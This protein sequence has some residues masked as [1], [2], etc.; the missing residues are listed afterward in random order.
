MRYIIDRFEGQFAVCEDENQEMVNILTAKLPIGVKEGD[1]LE[2]SDGS[3]S[4]L[5]EESDKVKV[6]IGK[7]MDDLFE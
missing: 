4:I 7:L 5:R 6:E 2:E 1:I 3:Y